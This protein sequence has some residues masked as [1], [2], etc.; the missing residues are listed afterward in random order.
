MDV[1]TPFKWVFI[2]II[3]A[4]SSKSL[5]KAITFD[6]YLFIPA[7]YYKIPKHYRMEDITIEEIMDKLDV[8]KEIFGKVDEFSW[9]YMERI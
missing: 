7:A 8:F 3:P 5:T 9:W 4:K 6:N 2:V 1:K